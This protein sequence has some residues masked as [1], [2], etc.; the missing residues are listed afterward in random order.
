M[1]E[2]LSHLKMSRVYEKM[3]RVYAV[4]QRKSISC[5]KHVYRGRASHVINMYRGH[6]LCILVQCHCVSL[7][8]DSAHQAW[9][10]C[11]YPLDGPTILAGW[12]FKTTFCCVFFSPHLSS[13]T[14][15]T[16]SC[17]IALAGLELEPDVG[18]ELV[19]SL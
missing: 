7:W 8:S 10:Q 13:G 17:C 3:S 12:V 11:P 6:T 1:D 19:L 4:I 18:R 16:E 9:R 15:K 5:Y 2:S 14:D